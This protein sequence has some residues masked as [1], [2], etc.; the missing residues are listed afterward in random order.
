MVGLALGNLVIGTLPDAT[1]RRKPLLVSLALYV[2]ASI[3]CA[4][5]TH[6]EPLMLFRLIR[7]FTGGAGI[8]LSRAIA[9]DLYH[10]EELTKFLA[11]LMLV[12]GAAPVLPPMLGGYKQGVGSATSLIGV[13]QYFIGSIATPLVGLMG[14]GSIIPYVIVV[15]FFYLFF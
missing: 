12:N 15:Y 14:E 9:T 2:V 3:V 5:T 10:G 6:I 7:G 4:T 8:V 1:G 13:M 11:L